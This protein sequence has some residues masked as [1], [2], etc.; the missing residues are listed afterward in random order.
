VYGAVVCSYDAVSLFYLELYVKLSIYLSISLG[1][2]P[3]PAQRTLCRTTTCQRPLPS[4]HEPL[5]SRRRTSIDLLI[6]WKTGE[7]SLRAIELPLSLNLGAAASV[8]FWPASKTAFCYSIR[9]L[10]TS[11]GGSIRCFHSFLLSCFQFSH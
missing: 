3:Q 5:P 6:F 1:A 7:D 8:S 10:V 4:A 11:S 9:H 2:A